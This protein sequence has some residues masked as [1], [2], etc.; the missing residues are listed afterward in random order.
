MSEAAI[1]IFDSGVGGLTVFNAIAQSLPNEQLIYLGD[2]ARVPYGTKTAASV[3][4]YAQQASNALVNQGIKMLVIA[5]NTATANALE[6][7]QA[8]YAPLPVIGVIEPG[9]QL[10]SITSQKRHIGVIAT[11]G[12]VQGKAYDQALLAKDPELQLS[13]QAC[14]LFVALAEDGWVQGPLVE[15]V[16]EHYLLPIF[17]KHQSNWPDTLVLGCTHFPLLKQAIGNVLGESVQLI[18]SAQAVAS[19][20]KQQLIK[21]GLR[22]QAQ[23]PG[24]QR[25]LVTDGPER[26]ARLGSFFLGRPLSQDCIQVV[27]L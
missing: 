24:Q 7:L 1:G 15:R 4:Q 8:L 21:H 2:S 20:V 16:I 10:A 3:R 13:S 25:F 6:H 23:S 27:D 18:D 14:S 26:F 9:A 17:P 12:T 5:C 22:S 19:E 11:E